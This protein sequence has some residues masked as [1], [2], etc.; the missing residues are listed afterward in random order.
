MLLYLS[1]ML[2]L[3][4]VVVR[5]DYDDGDDDRRLSNSKI[6]TTAIKNM[7]CRF[8]IITTSGTTAGAG[9]IFKI[10]CPCLFAACTRVKG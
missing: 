1:K 6:A 3:F 10:S 9:T 2:S 4:V 5:R 7:I 8:V